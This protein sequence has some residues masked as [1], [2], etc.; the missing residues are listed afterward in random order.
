MT[1][2]LLRFAKQTTLFPAIP[3]ATV[4]VPCCNTTWVLSTLSRAS[5]SQRY[6]PNPGTA[7]F[8]SQEYPHRLR[9]CVQ[10]CFAIWRIFRLEASE[11]VPPPV[12]SELTVPD[13]CSPAAVPLRPQQQSVRSEHDE[14]SMPRVWACCL[15]CYD[16]CFAIQTSGFAHVRPSSFEEPCRYRKES[17]LCSG[18]AGLRRRDSH[19]PSFEFW[20]CFHLARL[21]N[22]V[23]PKK[24]LQWVTLRVARSP[25]N[26]S[27]TSRDVRREAILS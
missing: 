15:G 23:F 27:A 19:E 11:A 24:L 22:D 14:S 7:L 21:A 25:D 3:D 20:G 4:E 10:G 8:H 1:S 9:G 13:A 6:L 17:K 18:R 16:S 5:S 12:K 26:N 2:I